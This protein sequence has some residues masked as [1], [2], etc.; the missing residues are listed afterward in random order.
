MNQKNS[1]LLEKITFSLL[2]LCSILSLVSTGVTI[3]PYTEQLLLILIGFFCLFTFIISIQRNIFLDCIKNCKFYFLFTLCIGIISTIKYINAIWARE[4][5]TFFTVYQIVFFV[6]FGFFIYVYL[7]DRKSKIKYV[8]LSLSIP[9][10]IIVLVYK[11][12]FMLDQELY[13]LMGLYEN[14]NILGLFCVVS[15][16]SSLY[17]FAN[18]KNFAF[19]HALCFSICAAA[20]LLTLSRGAIL[21]LIT[22][23]VLIGFSSLIN[24]DAI[25]WR[26]LIKNVVIICAMT[27][28]FT[29]I[30]MPNASDMDKAFVVGG[31]SAKQNESIEKSDS[32][33]KSDVSIG[34]ELLENKIIEND[35]QTKVNNSAIKDRF[36]LSAD[37]NSSIL[38][39]LRI[40]IWSAYFDIA[41]KYWAFGTDY[42]LTER[43]IVDGMVRDPHNTFIYTLFRY[44][45]FGLITFTVLI[46]SICFNFILHNRKQMASILIFALFLSIMIISCIND[47]VNTSIFFIVIAVTLLEMSGKSDDKEKEK[48]VHVLQVFSS[49]NKGGAESRMMDIYR[50]L[51]KESIQMDFAVLSEDV[52][53]Q[54]YYDE[55]RELGGEIY[56]IQSL[57]NIGLYK[58]LKQWKAILEKNKYDVMH[59]HSSLQSWIPL[60]IALIFGVEKRIA[61]ARDSG[62]GKRNIPKKIVDVFSHILIRLVSTDRI[63]CSKEAADYVFGKVLK[64]S[65]HCYFLP[66]AINI[67]DF[68][69]ISED[70]IKKIK[71]EIGIE[72]FSY[73]I[74]TVGNSRPVKNHTF[75]VQVLHYLIK[76]NVNVVLLIVGDNAKDDEAKK[77]IKENNLEENVC[78]LGVR[79]DMPELLQIFDVFVLPSLFEGA[80]GSVVEAQAVNVPCVLS[81]T[82]THAIDVGSGL[83][84]YISLNSSLQSWA[85]T[86]VKCCK[87]SRKSFEETQTKLKN[88]GYDV[89]NARDRLM[90]IYVK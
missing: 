12:R 31:E 30:F 65:T 88:K 4:E 42:S 20:L 35:D 11:D 62:F 46:A 6:L 76:M 66:N 84:E 79:N 3:I 36:S 83:L 59:V 64:I 7:Y 58:Y 48:I 90:E 24:H 85:E 1:L 73:I 81:D 13:R 57:H 69:K 21:G 77:Y 27:A 49:I 47:L 56:K 72:N 23:I 34:E 28:I 68:T 41:D 45:I 60:T 17:L 10:T 80:P 63:Y 87:K 26:A 22:G 61:H 39:N 37:N 33:S 19:V 15:C 32:N 8:L 40:R 51:D 55:I 25:Q 78:F 89:F 2:I 82:I 5:I 16:F 38:H 52:E 43:P 44:G 18:A 54:F 9:L 70:K 71:E 29:I 53:T 74:G 67:K 14:P 86:I 75:L 50:I